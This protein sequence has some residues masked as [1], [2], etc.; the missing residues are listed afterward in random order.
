M[1]SPEKYDELYDPA[2]LATLP[3]RVGR[4]VQRT[5]YAQVENE[6]SDDDILIGLMDSPVI[7]VE[8]VRAHN[9]A[10]GFENA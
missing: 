3:W 4:K 5:I 8:A 9:A 7:S 1:I 6:P 2:T 10:L